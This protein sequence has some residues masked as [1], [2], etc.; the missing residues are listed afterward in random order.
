MCIFCHYIVPHTA[1]HCAKHFF[2]C[3]RRF[4]W[5]WK[6]HPVTM[7]SRACAQ[8]QFVH[9]PTTV[10]VVPKNEW[11]RR[12]VCAGAEYTHFYWFRYYY[13]FDCPLVA[14]HYRFSIHLFRSASQSKHHRHPLPLS[15]SHTLTPKW[16]HIHENNEFGQLLNLIFEISSCV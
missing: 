8:F 16:N 6:F 1:K 2:R 13:T 15:L 12:H 5:H 9:V 4:C 7:E 11:T 3:R 10:N 14:Q